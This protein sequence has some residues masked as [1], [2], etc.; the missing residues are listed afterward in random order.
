MKG[1][2]LCVEIA[3]ILKIYEI[4]FAKKTIVKTPG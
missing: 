2:F 1:L 4:Y 3:S